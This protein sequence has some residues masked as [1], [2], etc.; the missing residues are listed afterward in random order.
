MLG[1]K[2]A[3]RLRPSG[4]L[5][6]KSRRLSNA[7]VT[8][9]NQRCISSLAASLR[10]HRVTTNT[11][12]RSSIIPQP[13]PLHLQYSRYTPVRFLSTSDAGFDGTDDAQTLK[14][15][16]L[17]PPNAGKSTLFNRLMDKETNK[18]YRLASE[19]TVRKPT[20]SRVSQ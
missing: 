5:L 4:S 11:N 2:M 15:A 7:V 3:M 1:S 18:S 12:S 19:K 8:L 10:T 13:Q 9:H 14:I 16:I 20:R 6:L 17:G